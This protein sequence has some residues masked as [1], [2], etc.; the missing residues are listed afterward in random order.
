VD[1][2]EAIDRWGPDAFRYYILREVPWNGDGDF[3]WERFDARYNADLADDFGNL[4]NRTISMIE[5]YRG[6]IVPA[7]ARTALDTDIAEA[8]ER[9]RAAMDANLLH[10]G[11]AAAMELAAAANGFVETSAPWSAAREPAR[12]AELDATLASLARAIAA[13]ASLLAPFIPV[14]VEEL[15]ERLGLERLPRLDEIR[16]LDLAGHRVARGPVLFPKPSTTPA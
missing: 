10:F 7:G 8:V 16:A 11:A 4:A 15:L 3:S 6:G 5:K 12:A 14:K 9:Y 1:L 13:I 2:E